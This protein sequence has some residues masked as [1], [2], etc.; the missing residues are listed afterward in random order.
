MH[1]CTNTSSGGAASESQVIS[2]TGLGSPPS[3]HSLPASGDSAAVLF[4]WA[5]V[6]T[7]T[8]L[9]LRPCARIHDCITPCSPPWPRLV[10]SNSC[11]IRLAEHGSS[12]APSLRQQ[13]DIDG[14]AGTQTNGRS[15]KT[16]MSLEL[17][18]GQDLLPTVPSGSGGVPT[19]RLT[20][21]GWRTSPL[22]ACARPS[23]IQAITTHYSS[24]PPSIPHHR[25]RTGTLAR[26]CSK[27][28][29]RVQSHRRLLELW[30][31]AGFVAV[32]AAALD[33]SSET[34]AAFSSSR[35]RMARGS[36]GHCMLIQQASP[37]QRP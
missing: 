11:R 2:G 26:A 18:V 13:E 28:T 31:A 24:S 7:W 1:Y 29:L 34:R 25:I 19:N 10:S 4:A 17:L 5:D 3:A 9:G 16:T 14:R 36:S 37:T 27:V 35:S 6:R 30:A 23:H 20:S 32:F 12:G 21:A 22:G 15:S 33:G 8:L